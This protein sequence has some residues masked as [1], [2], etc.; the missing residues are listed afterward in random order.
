MALFVGTGKLTKNNI[1]KHKSNVTLFYETK[2]RRKQQCSNK[3]G[4]DRV[5]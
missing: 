4:E 1:V 2:E 5:A 3:M